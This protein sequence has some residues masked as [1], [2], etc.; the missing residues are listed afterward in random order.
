MAGFK[1]AATAGTRDF[2]EDNGIPCTAATLDGNGP[3]LFDSLRSGEYAL[4]INTPSRGRDK[5]RTGF[6]I[7]RAAVEHNCACLTSLDTAGALATG[8][9]RTAGSARTA[10][11]RLAFRIKKDAGV[12]PAAFCVIVRICYPVSTILVAV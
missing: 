2:L 8:L 4:V 5:D 12:I 7:R 10:Q 1:I 6:R 11:H 3:T 9:S